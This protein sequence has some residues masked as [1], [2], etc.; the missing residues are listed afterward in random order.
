MENPV[1]EIC[2][3]WESREE[4]LERTSINC[5]TTKRTV[6][7]YGAALSGSSAGVLLS[8]GSLAEL[9]NLGRNARWHSNG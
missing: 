3:D 2:G 7:G 1:S 9:D 4:Q 8:A 6:T 5:F